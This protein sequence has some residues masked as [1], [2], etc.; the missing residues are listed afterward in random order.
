MKINS[1]ITLSFDPAESSAAQRITSKQFDNL[2]RTLTVTLLPNGSGSAIP[3]GA[4][5]VLRGTKPDSTVFDIVGTPLGKKGRYSFVFTE[6]NLSA[7][8]MI[9]CDIVCSW[10]D[11]ESVFT[12]SSEIFYIENIAAAVDPNSPRIAV[13]LQSVE[14]ATE[15]AVSAAENANSVASELLAAKDRGEF[16]GKDGKD[17]KSAENIPE[18][19]YTEARRVA[20]SVT[21][22]RN[23]RSFVFA[24][25]S[26]AHI[27]NNPASETSAVHGGMGL[28]CLRELTNI[29][30]AAHLGDYIRGSSDSTKAESR[31]EYLIYHKAMQAGC[32][33]IPTVWIEGNHDANYQGGTVD[34]VQTD[35]IFTPDELYAHIGANN[36]GTHINEYGNENGL[37]GYIDFPA[38]RLRVIYLNTSD[39]WKTGFSDAQANWLSTVGFDFSDKDDEASWGF[40]LLLHIP[41]TFSDNAKLLSAINSYSG[42]AEFIAIFH[43]HCH[44]FRKEKVGTAQIWQIGIP[45]LCVGRNNEYASSSDAGYS[46]IFGEFDSDG[47]PVYYPKTAD[48]AQDTS[49]NIVTIDRTNRL[50]HCHVFGAGCDRTVSYDKS[51]TVVLCNI[52]VS[53]VNMSIDNSVRTVESGSPYTAKLT[54]YDGYTIES[55]VVKMNGQDIT[56]EV[57]SDGI[58]NIPAV[59]GGITIGG[60]AVEIEVEPDPEPDL[61][62]Y[63]N[64]FSAS[65]ADFADAVRFNGSGATT[66]GSAFCSGY[67]PVA[68]DDTVYVYCPNGDYA[69]D[70]IGAN[71]RCLCTYASDK[72]VIGVYYPYDMTLDSDNKGFNYTVN[73][74]SVAFVRVSGHPS[75]DYSG[76]V[77]T[78]NEVIPR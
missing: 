64:L 21:S 46:S 34:G 7:A 28:R 59:T 33:G 38:K 13:E 24:A 9:R 45:E 70:S 41:V 22:V 71:V 52:L 53:L 55:V 47:N 76:F 20:D 72:S 65:D 68:K 12:K 30:M 61:E 67:I 16:D 5:V 74:A 50:I 37:Y 40:V 3:D 26:D 29:D 57:Y 8:G 10:N 73:D 36:Q 62:P 27:A 14:R 35:D 1:N 31:E 44:N 17:G 32:N 69:N 78:K 48:T 23:G 58:I 43:G 49:F 4:E 66:A 54:A 42:E 77:I 6:S 60:H 2:T 39:G 19:V 63:T 18:Y 25:F 75:G 56:A 11:G 15:L 51:E